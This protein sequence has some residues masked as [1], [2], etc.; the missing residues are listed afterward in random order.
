M[1]KRTHPSAVMPIGNSAALPGS[2]VAKSGNCASANT[3]VPGPL[4]GP[5]TK[6]LT[7]VL[8]TSKVNQSLLKIGVLSIGDRKGFI[9]RDTAA[10]GC[11][12]WIHTDIQIVK[13]VDRGQSVQVQYRH[14]RRPSR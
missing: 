8:S 11:A 10:L 5:V 1:H 6:P 3:V 4:F 7:R 9:G 13:I 2:G 14:I 12:L